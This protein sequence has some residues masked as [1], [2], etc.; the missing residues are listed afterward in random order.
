MVGFGMQ[1]YTD[2]AN[3][4]LCRTRSKRLIHD[5]QTDVCDGV[6][7]ADIIEAVSKYR[8]SRNSS[9]VPFFLLLSS[10]YPLLFHVSFIPSLSLISSILVSFGFVSCFLFFHQFFILSSFFV[11][12]SCHF[13][14]F[15]FL[16]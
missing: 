9:F 1:V 12:P 5:L 13:F 15:Y 10:S 11:F 8:V 2:W 4:Y 6:L 3:H 7:L 14:R 16:H